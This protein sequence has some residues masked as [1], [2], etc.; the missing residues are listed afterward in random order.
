MPLQR[1]KDEAIA[2]IA[3]PFCATGFGPEKSLNCALA[4]A[5]LRG[6]CAGCQSE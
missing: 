4:K 2:A 3:S 6:I 5:E 1:P